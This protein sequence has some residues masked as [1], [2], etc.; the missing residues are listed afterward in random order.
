MRISEGVDGPV[1]VTALALSSGEFAG[2]SVIFVSCDLGGFRH[3]WH[4]ENNFLPLC[5]EAIRERSPEIDLK[6]VVL[7]A[8][9]THTAPNALKHFFRPIGIPRQM[10]TDPE[11]EEARADLAELKAKAEQGEKTFRVA[12]RRRRMLQRYRQQK[13]S[14]TL[15]MDLH[16]V[17][18]GN[19]AF[20]TNRFE[21][22]LDYGIRMKA[23]R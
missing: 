17:R 22:F 21:L 1:T 18:L 19:V 13:E 12:Q 4:E 20:V 3:R 11:A 15:T 6:N 23:G 16:A 8:T 9:H 2:E 10:V 5:R 14:P 7:N